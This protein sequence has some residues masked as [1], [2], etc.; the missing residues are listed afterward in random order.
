MKVLAV[1]VVTENINMPVLPVGLASVAAAARTEGH[2]VEVLHLDSQKSHKEALKDAITRLQPDLIAFSVRNIDDQN[3]TNPSFLLK[4]VQDAIGFCREYTDAPIV[5][6][7]AGYTMYPRP[8]LLWLGADFGIAGDGEA[9]FVEMLARL[10]RR[11]A[12][13]GIPGLHQP[14][15]KQQ[16]RPFRERK[17][18][19]WPLPLPGSDLVASPPA[20]DAPLWVPVQTRRG[21]PLKCSYCSTPV[22]EGTLIRKRDSSKVVKAIAQWSKAGFKNFFFVDNTFNLPESY[23]MKLCREMAK[24]RLGISW[25]AIVYPAR[26]SEELV[27][28]MA[29]AGCTGVSLGFE[30]GSPLMLKVFNKRFGTEDIRQACNLFKKHGIRCQGF[31]LLG[32]P[33]ETRQT[34][35]QSFEFVDSLELDQCKITCGIRIYPGTWIEKVARNS[36]VVLPDDD[37]LQPRF[38]LEPGLS[39]WLEQ[40]AQTWMETRP[41]WGG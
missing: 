11:Q 7:G 26:I 12:L 24:A 38:Y 16:V 9:P 1:Y 28:A 34:V 6:G 40:E 20:E 25:M 22:I 18:D 13:D 23:A 8:A 19:C 39:G 32:G 17:P 14:Q 30:S 21:C 4:P 33:G 27:G 36:G 41:H 15:D 5:L 10:E 3:A 35:L 29:A 31:L 2:R 37:L